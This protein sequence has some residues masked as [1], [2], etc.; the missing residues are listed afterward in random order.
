M[1]MLFMLTKKGNFIFPL[2]LGTS[3]LAMGLLG[4]GKSFSRSIHLSKVHLQSSIARAYMTELLELF[5]SF[6]PTQF[7]DFLSLNRA[8]AEL[9]GYPL[10][11]HINL[12]TPNSETILNRDPVSK[13]PTSALGEYANRFYQIQVINI[14]TLELQSAYCDQIADTVT[15]AANERFYASV[16]VTWYPKG[17]TSSKKIIASTIVSTQE[18][19]Q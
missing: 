2:I 1:V 9:A 6:Q 14:E 4:F 8:D 3:V 13:L 17:A 16:G 10:C 12:M 15:L 19:G 5:Y 11:A 7:Q 18:N